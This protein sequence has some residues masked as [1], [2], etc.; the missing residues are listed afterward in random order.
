MVPITAATYV[1]SLPCQGCSADHSLPKTR[2]A[3]TGLLVWPWSILVAITTHR[4]LGWEDLKHQ[5]FTSPTSGGWK[6]KIRGRPGWV[7]GKVFWAADCSLSLCPHMVG[8]ARALSSIRTGPLSSPLEGP[9]T[10]QTGSVPTGTLSSHRP[11]LVCCLGVVLEIALGSVLH[12]LDQ[13]EGSATQTRPLAGCCRPWP[14]EI[15]HGA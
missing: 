12:T 9:G 15:D 7:L 3:G 8:G 13:S 2:V 4:R 14:L 10:G 5:K 6:P 1:R 11:V